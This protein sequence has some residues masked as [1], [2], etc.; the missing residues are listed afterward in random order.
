[1]LS[2]M[3]RG[4]AAFV[5]HGKWTEKQDTIWRCVWEIATGNVVLLGISRPAGVRAKIPE[6]GTKIRPKI[7]ILPLKNNVN[8]IPQYA[9]QK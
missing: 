4:A 6:N 9:C 5:D 2:S 8:P 1:M 7:K 3:M